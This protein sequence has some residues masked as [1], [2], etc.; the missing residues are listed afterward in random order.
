MRHWQINLTRTAMLASAVLA[1]ALAASAEDR[2]RTA[3][4]IGQR[5]EIE[6]V[7]E[8]GLRM[9]INGRRLVV[10]FTDIHSRW[11]DAY[12]QLKEAEELYEK[13]VGGDADAMKKAAKLY[14]GLL[15]K[16]APAWLRTVVQW[17]MYS[18]YATSGLVQKALDAYLSMAKQSPKLV[19]DLALPAPAADQHELNRRMLAQVEKVLET[20][21]NAPYADAL[22][23]FRVSL[24]LLE[25]DPKDILAGGIL[26]KPLASTDAGVRQSAMFKKMD[27]LTALGRDQEASAW[28]EK[29]KTS[30]PEADP[31]EMAYWKGRILEKQGQPID[32]ALAFMRLPVLYPRLNVQRTADALW[33]AGKALEAAEAPKNE[34]QAVYQEAVSDYAGTTGAERAR[35]ELARLGA[36]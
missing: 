10:P 6:D 29:I 36:E 8:D 4:G 31:A 20:A 22:R 13:G 5:G 35:R 33:R 18:V 28:F 11:S 19:T 26:D 1:L 7:T 15:T 32:A 21:G 30:E 27:L 9:K 14:D 23:N 17:R 12:P 16:G 34:A 25:G 2:V 3:E 24:M